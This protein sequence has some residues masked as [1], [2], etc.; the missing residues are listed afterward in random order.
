ML[1]FLA[2]NLE[3]LDLALEHVL[4]EDANN[5]RFGLMLTDNAVEIT[6]HQLAADKMNNLKMFA[7]MREQYEEMAALE[8]ALGQHF[9]PKVKF[10]KI[11]SKLS[12]EIAESITILHVFRNEVYHI[13]VQHEPV[14]PTLA[15]FYFKLACDFLGAYEPPFLSWGSDQRL[16]E[17]AKKFFAGDKTF[18]GSADQYRTACKA[19]GDSLDYDPS[20]IPEALADHMSEIIEEQDSCIDLVATGGPARTTR[21]KAVI[22][23]QAWPLAFS[24]EGKKYAQEQ[25]W[26]G[27]NF[28]EF[29]EWIA[30]KYPLEFCRDPVPAWEERVDNLR[31][32]ANPRKA[33]KKY[34]SFMD[35][36][37]PIREKLYDSALQVE[38]YIDEQIDRMKWERR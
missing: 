38:A 22:D 24:Q 2:N 36:T 19:M 30:E 29:V 14:L 35:Q 18:P 28:L 7:H 27:G 15:V 10:A 33:L 26:T 21:D 6:L 20:F 16:P 13:G 12:D 31:R 11:D 37:A 5:A 34:R 25:G 32:E 23:T 4:K 3:Q 8:R 1:R 9:A 17:R